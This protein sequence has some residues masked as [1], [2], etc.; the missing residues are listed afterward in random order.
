MAFLIEET[1]GVFPLWLSPVQVRLIPVSLEH[2]KEF[3][4]NL[5]NILKKNKIRVETDYRDEKLGYKIR[6]AQTQK[7]PF[8]LVI[9]DK[10]VESNTVTYRRYGDTAQVTVSIDEF[11]ELVKNEIEAHK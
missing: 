4:D 7:I 3:T 5:Y 6:E 2:H 10:E 11:V 9:G 1:K 8:G